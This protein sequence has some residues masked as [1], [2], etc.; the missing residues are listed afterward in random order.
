MIG[1]LVGT[2]LL[3]GCRPDGF[4][5]GSTG[6]F[7]L[8]A[9]ALPDM[10]NGARVDA[11]VPVAGPVTG[12]CTHAGDPTEK[13]VISSDI[14]ET[15][16]TLFF[17]GLLADTTYRCSVASGGLA[18]QID[19]ATGPL[20]EEVP[21]DLELTVDDG[22]SHGLSDGA[23]TLFNHMVGD[24]DVARGR[25]VIVDRA[26]RVRWYW[27]F[28][29]VAGDIDAGLTPEGNVLLGG[30]YGLAP[31][32]VSLSGELI[33][34]ASEPSSGGQWHHHAEMTAA[35]TYFALS[36]ADN[37]NPA[38][39]KFEFMGFQ[40]DERD[41]RT[42]AVVW[43]W[44]SQTAVDAGALPV[45]STEGY[46][47]F[48]ANSVLG[49]NPSDPGG[50]WVSLRNL[51][52]IVRIEKATGAVTWRMSNQGDDWALLDDAGQPAPTEQW[53]FGQ[54]APEL[55]GDTLYVYDNGRN[56]PG[57]AN[58]RVVAYALDLAARTL[59]QSWEWS[60]GEWY[61]PIWG[62]V[63]LLPNGNVLVT[64]GH[65]ED[66]DGTDGVSRWIELDPETGPVWELQTPSLLHAAYRAQRLD[67]CTI[68][69][70][71]A[72][73]PEMLVR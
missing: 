29:H 70:N 34:M 50:V 43:T 4:G 24:R 53:F 66:C 28:G 27:E 26:G 56:R 10:V 63:D 1:T 19:F 62:D 71:S 69:A 55:V 41:P 21:G 2:L 18:A 64:R 47:A 5:I 30:G 38:A 31:T 35:G 42:D 33:A 44:N 49:E 46:D 65:C 7:A 68:F 12:T 17:Y 8:D 37:V 22:A 57:G 39:P 6:D 59:R 61:E 52:A 45:P 23:Y 3:G 32:T 51:S 14:E 60:G 36:E 13:H 72:Y 48:H 9:S 73:C 11:R 40:I 25:L 54:H 20:P 15:E 16:H 67:G 58:S